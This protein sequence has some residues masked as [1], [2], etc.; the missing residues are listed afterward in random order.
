MNKKIMT[1][2]D[3]KNYIASI[4]LASAILF[5]YGYHSTVDAL[6]VTAVWIFLSIAIVGVTLL[7]VI[8]FAIRNHKNRNDQEA[9]P[10]YKALSDMH[11]R[12]IVKRLIGFVMIGYWLYALIVQEWTVTAV[13]YLITVTYMEAFIFATKDIAK[14]FFLSRLKGE[15]N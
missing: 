15:G 8:T 5:G 9:G 4:A 12:H 11:D 1:F 14:E 10:F 13:V 7:T 6:I 3:F 2:G